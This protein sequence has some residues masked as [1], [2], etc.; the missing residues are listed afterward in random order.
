MKPL[1]KEERL[2]LEKLTTLK[3]SK[4]NGYFRYTL[5]RNDM[6]KHFR[7]SRVLMQLHL[8]KRLEFWE[9]V[10]HKDRNKENDSME[11]LEVVDT[12]DFDSHVALHHNDKRKYIQKERRGIDPQKI[13]QIKKLSKTITR[14]GKPNYSKIGKELNLSGQTVARYCLG[15]SQN[16]DS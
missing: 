14:N 2:F 11:N 4:N 7:R 3:P 6:V 16:Y 5:T 10:H 12:K 13:R 8:N 15:F 1:T 9:I